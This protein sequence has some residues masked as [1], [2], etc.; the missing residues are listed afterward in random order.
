MCIYIYI[1]IYIYIFRWKCLSLLCLSSRERP[2]FFSCNVGDGVVTR[3]RP[4]VI[5]YTAGPRATQPDALRVRPELAQ[6]KAL[7]V[8]RGSRP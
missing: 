6:S 4:S 5:R 2:F 1:Y 8:Y 3:T 7:A